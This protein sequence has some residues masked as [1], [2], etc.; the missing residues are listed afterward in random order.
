[1]KLS[2]VEQ[3]NSLRTIYTQLCFCYATADGDNRDHTVDVLQQGLQTLTEVLPW[4]AGQVVRKDGVLNVVPL[5]KVPELV[6]KDLTLDPS[7]PTLQQLR[8]AR[9]PFSMLKEEIICPRNTTSNGPGEDESHPYP[10]LLLQANFIKGGVLLSI[11]ACHSVMDIIGQA[12]V[13]RLLSSACHGDPIPDEVIANCNLDREKLIPSLNDNEQFSRESDAVDTR[14]NEVSPVSSGAASSE[15]PKLEWAYFNFAASA[16]SELKKLTTSTLPDSSSFVSTDDCICALL[17]QS[18]A[19]VRLHRLN[20]AMHLRFLRQVDVRKYMEIPETYPGCMVTSVSRS[21]S[22]GEVTSESLGSVAS[23][24]RELLMDRQFFVHSVRAAATEVR[25]QIA[26]GT[27]TNES[28]K[29]K[30]R[31][32]TITMSSWSKAE[33]HNVDFNLG[34]GKPTAVRRP[35]FTPIEGIVYLLPKGPDGDVVAGLCLRAQEIQG[36]RNDSEFSK[37]AEYIG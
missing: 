25:N 13:I 16:L 20:S 35:Q 8:D 17:W 29:K 24:L 32:N 15:A 28:D 12:L 33:C 18:L 31:E 22:L 30:D 34:L 14:A 21:L 9:F 4:L 19:R 11:L 2:A 36:L 6:T 7:A 26:H 37:W 27:G 23:L 1:M 10:V 3:S 5:R